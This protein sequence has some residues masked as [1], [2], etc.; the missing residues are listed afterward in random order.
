[1]PPSTANPS[2]RRSFSSPQAEMMVDMKNCP[3]SDPSIGIVSEN[4]HKVGL[5]LCKYCECGQ[6]ACP[7]NKQDL[8][9]RSTFKTKYSH[10]YQHLGFDSP[11]KHEP[12]RF[13]PNKLKMDFQTTNQHDFK[14]FT[15]T[16]KQTEESP[17]SPVK[18]NFSCRTAYASEFPNWGTQ[19]PVYE[20]RFHPPV[21]SCEI[22]F[23][24]RSSYSDYYR[25]VSRDE[26]DIYRTDYTV[27]QAFNSTISIAP[28]DKLNAN[29]TYGDH[30][31]FYSCSP[32]NS[33]IIVKAEDPT[34]VKAVSTHFR[35]TSGS[36]F[37][38]VKPEYKDPRLMK[39]SLMSRTGNRIGKA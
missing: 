37:K 36:F 27:S 20:K 6:H 38:N 18:A 16:P 1:M 17:V 33:K 2:K 12:K 25:P 28:K 35:T 32:L 34:Q 4:D 22:P 11:I 3:L 39:F 23:R 10:D 21:R 24:G 29:T 26:A 14:P 31:R 19:V 15:V 13:R 30:M 8:Y 9:L 7:G 5:C